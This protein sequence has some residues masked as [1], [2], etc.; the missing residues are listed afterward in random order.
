[1]ETRAHR[2]RRQNCYY[3]TVVIDGREQEVPRPFVDIQLS[4]MRLT[5]LEAL[6]DFRFLSTEMLYQF[7]LLKHPNAHR[8]WFQ[9]S[10]TELR[11]KAGYIECN[12]DQFNTINADYK[13]LVYNLTR[14]RGRK[15]VERKPHI[16]SSSFFH[17]WM[18]THSVASTKLMAHHEGVP[19]LEPLDILSRVPT[20]KS[21]YV[22]ET[23]VTWKGEFIKHRSSPDYPIWGLKFGDDANAFWD[24]IDNDTEDGDSDEIDYSNILQKIVCLN[25]LFKLD[26]NGDDRFW[27]RLHLPKVYIR[28]LTINERRKRVILETVKRV[29]GKS[30]RFLVKT[31]PYFKRIDCSPQLMADHW[32]TPWER[33]GYP[34]FYLNQIEEE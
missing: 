4:K 21:P 26:Q 12:Q 1:M 19:F 29:C 10:L 9:N 16:S 11:K 32:H 22:L 28:F 33:Q 15:F 17:D 6:A 14:H 5:I 24:E 27:Q 25:E 18:A 20:L 13:E 34:P 30:P 2:I 31:M 3:D 8:G 7:V 23:Q